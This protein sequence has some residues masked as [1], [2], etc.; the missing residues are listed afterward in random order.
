LKR[1]RFPAAAEPKR[2]RAKMQKRLYAASQNA[3][4]L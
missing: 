3:E 1:L 4:L 2:A